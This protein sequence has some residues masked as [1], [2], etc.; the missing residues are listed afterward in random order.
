VNHPRF[1]EFKPITIEDQKFIEEFITKYPSEACEIIFGNLFIWRN[2]EHARFTT[3]NDNLC[4][5]CEPPSEPPYFLQPIGENRMKETVNICLDFAQRLSR[6]P[7]KF[8]EEYCG[9]HR[10]DPDRDNFD[11]VYLTKNLIELKGKRYDGKRNRMRKFKKSHSYRYL[12]LSTEHLDDCRLLLEEWLA[13]KA[14]TD[15][16][17]IAQRDAILESLRY[18]ETLRLVGGAIEVEGRIAAFSIGEKLK[19]DIAVIHIEIVGSKY[20]GLSQ[21]MNHEFIKNEWSAYKFINREQDLGIAGLRRAKT[22]YN[23]HRMVKKYNVF[24]K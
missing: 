5:F 15:G 23:P 14:S 9:G 7:E 22:S 21:V 16:L 24:K 18:F 6:I 19:E 11:Y 12:K 3:V 17:L 1:P 20:E 8:V 2:Y 13:A 10:R 4:I